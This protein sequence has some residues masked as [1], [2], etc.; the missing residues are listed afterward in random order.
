MNWIIELFR[1][2]TSWIPR[3]YYI[4]PNEAGIRLTMGKG[5]KT[6]SSGWWF[7]WPVIHR[8]LDAC[9]VSQVVD[10]MP[11]SLRTKDGK[12]LT[13][14]LTI[15]F[16]VSDIRM[17]LLNVFDCDQALQNL[18][19]GVVAEYIGKHTFEECSD[20]STLMDKCKD[21]VQKA[22]RGW[23]ISIQALYVDQITDAQVIRLLMNIPTVAVGQS[24]E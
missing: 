8:I 22:A 9:V 18:T 10:L 3:L 15:R 7:Y 4:Q 12:T 20:V 14:S 21:A 11:Q 2:L 5:V 16:S 13:I 17:M 6:L 24:G 19:R 1:L 23:G